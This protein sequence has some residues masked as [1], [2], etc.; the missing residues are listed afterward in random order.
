MSKYSTTQLI[1]GKMNRTDNSPK[2]KYKW[3]ISA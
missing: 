2:K 1:N 3:P